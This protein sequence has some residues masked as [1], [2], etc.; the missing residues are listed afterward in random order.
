ML[1]RRTLW[2]ALFVAVALVSFQ[3]P[4]SAQVPNALTCPRQPS[5]NDEDWS[6]RCAAVERDRQAAEFGER[7]RAMDRRRALYEKQPPLPSARNRLLGRWQ[8]TSSGGDPI[9]QLLG[10]VSGCGALIGDGIVEFEPSRWAFSGRSGRTDRGP[11]S[12]RGGANGMVIV[13]P[14][15]GSDFSFLEFEFET[16]DRIHLA[17]SRCTLVRTNAA[18]PAGRG[19]GAAA[20]ARDA[21]PASAMAPAESAFEAALWKKWRGRRGYDCPNGE[22]V[23]VDSCTGETA[24]ASCVVVRVGLAPR[25]GAL[26]TF[27]ETYAVLTNRVASCKQRPLRVVD[28]TLG[29]AP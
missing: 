27:T 2:S 13:L 23:A 14:A 10:A 19:S 21:P 11:A 15:K 9:E 24:S 28:G 22:H 6:I 25:N 18:G 5:E 7:L 16:P 26:V 29:F 20:P 3:V 4:S 8:T 12:Y 17:T 1:T